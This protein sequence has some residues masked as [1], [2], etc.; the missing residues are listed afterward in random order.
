VI[1][2]ERRKKTSS[3]RIV[4]GVV[5]IRIPAWLTKADE[6]A[7]VADLVTKVVKQQALADQGHDLVQRTAALAE[8]YDLPSPT[9]IRWVTNQQHRWG[10]CTPDSGEI[11]I[12]SRLRNV[13]AYV[14]DYVIVHELAHLVEIG[15]GVEFR[16]LEQRFPKWERAEGF[17]DAMSLGEAAREHQA[18]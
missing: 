9:S 7:T 15:H 3:A 18:D 4:D 5:Q 2:S 6:A 10:S 1:R 17:L 14:L 12:S 13:P 16:A 11:R 8:K